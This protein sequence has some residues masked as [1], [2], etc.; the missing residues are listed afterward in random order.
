MIDMYIEGVVNP[1]PSINCLKVWKRIR[2]IRDMH[3]IS[4]YE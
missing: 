3:I 4:R 2:G 1:N